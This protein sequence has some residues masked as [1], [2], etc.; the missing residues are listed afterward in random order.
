MGIASLGSSLCATSLYGEENMDIKKFLFS[1]LLL[2]FVFSIEAYCQNFKVSTLID[3]PGDNLEFDVL[4]QDFNNLNGETFICWIN[5]IDSLYTVYLK[6]LA[7]TVSDNIIVSS[8]LLIKSNPQIAINRYDQGIKIVWQSYKDNFWQVFLK[9]FI[10]NQL[11]DSTVILDSLNTNPQISLN[12]HRLAWINNGNLF[13][14]EFYPILSSNILFDSLSCSSPD[15]VM[16]DSFQETEVLYEKNFTDSVKIC[17]TT[18]QHNENNPPVFNTIFLSNGVLSINPRFGLDR[19]I[20]FQT[21]ND[22]IWKAEY[23]EYEWWQTKITQ[24]TECNYF[25]PILFSYPIPTSA[26]NNYTP[27]FLAFDTDSII[28][29]K[30]IFIKAYT[31]DGL[32]DSLLNISQSGGNDFKPKATY[33]SDSDSVMVAIIWLHNENNKTDIWIA[34]E[35]FNPVPGDV[36][37]EYY[38]GYSFSL[39]QNYP[40]PFNPSTTIEYAIKKSDNVKIIIYDFLGR[41]VKTIVNGYKNVGNYKEIF[42]ASNLSSGIYYYQINSRNNTQTKT[43]VFLK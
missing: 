15:L 24:N 27:F 36:D 29:N 40:N 34:K 9:N 6:Q 4:S 28:G 16:D 14:K 7:P 41:E 21:K 13:I 10:G 17:L 18:Y 12:I 38:K 32:Y 42:N 39:S 37:D 25:N 20:A 30:E 19:E 33:I 1:L 8:D 26:P 22:T 43:M 35:K 2:P 5:K 11:S 31:Y 3:I 23:S